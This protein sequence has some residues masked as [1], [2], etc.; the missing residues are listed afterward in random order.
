MRKHKILIKQING[1]EEQYEP[2]VPLVWRNEMRMGEKNWTVLQPGKDFFT[3]L[4]WRKPSD[5]T[6]WMQHPIKSYSDDESK[7]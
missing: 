5:T 4:W 2:I 6:K 1:L 3:F 7:E